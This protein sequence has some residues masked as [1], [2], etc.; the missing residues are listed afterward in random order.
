MAFST[1]Q[2]ANTLNGTSKRSIL[3][4]SLYTG[5]L[6]RTLRHVRCS[7]HNSSF[8]ELAKDSWTSSLLT[9]LAKRRTAWSALKSNQR[10]IGEF[11]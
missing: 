4:L 6:K 3:V 5:L 9:K 8:C 1:L 7:S 11:W 2:D 10:A